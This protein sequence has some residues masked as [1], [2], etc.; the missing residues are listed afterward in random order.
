MLQALT[1]VLERCMEA[2]PREANFLRS[3]SD[4]VDTWLSEYLKGRWHRSRFPLWGKTTLDELVRLEKSLIERSR[5]ELNGHEH[6]K[7]SNTSAVVHDF[8]VSYTSPDLDWA[9]WIAWTLEE[10]GY[11]VVLQD[12]DFRPGEN[13]VLRMDDAAKR[14]RSTIAV[15]SNAYLASAFPQ[16]EWAVAFSSDPKSGKKRLIPIKV[17]ECKPEGLLGQVIYINLVGLSE[18]DARMALLGGLTDRGKPAL[19]PEFPVG[20]ILY[21]GPSQR[22]DGVLVQRSFSEHQVVTPV[23][24]SAQASK[25]LSLQG[26]LHLIQTLNAIPPETFNMLVFVLD[27]PP[28]IIAPMPA[29]QGQ[30]SGQLL[31]WA[32]SPGGCTLSVIKD[33]LEQILHPSTI[34]SS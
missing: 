9:R 14:T 8:F 18:Q 12:W 22:S 23:V 10:A 33:I 5:N 24:A 34:E 32:E 4:I 6:M 2:S 30:R 27:P 3:G 25:I 15:L 13:F 1:I 17:R 11:S 26:R 29:P 16:P 20:N 28:G 21:P 31:S 19:A 7:Q